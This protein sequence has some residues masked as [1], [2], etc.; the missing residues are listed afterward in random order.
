MNLIFGS[1][2]RQMLFYPIIIYCTCIYS[3]ILPVVQT[4]KQYL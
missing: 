3:I 1:A 2:F 4:A